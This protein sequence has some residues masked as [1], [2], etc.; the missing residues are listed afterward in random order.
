MPA[1]TGYK[2]GMPCWADLS[3]ADLAVSVAFYEGLFGWR[4][5]FDPRPEAGGYGYFRQRDK[6]VA[7]IAL[8]FDRARP[9]AWNAYIAADDAEP[10]AL[11]VKEA[12]GHVVTGPVQVFDEGTMAVFRD[13]SGAAFMVWQAGRHHGAQ[14]VDE[15]VALCRLHLDTRDPMA[16]RS[17]YPAVFGWG[18]RTSPDG[19]YTE[20]LADGR[21]VAGMPTQPGPPASAPEAHA[22]A[23]APEARTGSA[24]PEAGTGAVAAPDARWLVCFAVADC[25]ATSALAEPWGG[26]VLRPPSDLPIGRLAVLADPHDA[27]FAVVTP[28]SPR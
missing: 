22:G 14:L 6:L 27:S 13:P 5:E 24:V 15:P 25:D 19:R 17:F 9:S 23:I 18:S 16:A 4:A 1:R 20:W 28:R 8:A 3:S 10:V 11:K 2:P 21:P 26:G 7:G 12:G